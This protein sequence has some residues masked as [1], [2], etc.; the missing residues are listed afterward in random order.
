MPDEV[1]SK[2]EGSFGEDFSDV[3]INAN[4]QSAVDAG[5]LAYTQGNNINFAPSQFKPDTQSGQELLGHELTHVVQQR[6]GQ[7]NPTGE[8]NGMPLNDDKRLENE[9]DNKGKEAAQMKTGPDGYASRALGMRSRLGGSQS[10][11][12][13]I[14]RH[15]KG[16]QELKDGKMELDFTK[17][18][19]VAK[20]DSANEKGWVKFHPNEKAPDSKSIKLVQ[21]VRNIDVTGI[22]TAKG[23]AYDWSGSAEANRNKVNTKGNGKD[24]APNFSVDHFASKSNVRTKKSDAEVSPFYMDHGPGTEGSKQGKTIVPATLYDAPG[25]TSPLKWSFVTAA[26]DTNTGTYYGTALWGFETYHDDKGITKIK[27]EYK[28]FRERQGA[29][30]DAAVNEFNEFYKNPGSSNAPKK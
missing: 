4:S 2:M 1:K 28:S 16:S 6:K 22:S 21:I 20:G 18:D 15:I 10:A 25:W 3:E 29:T 7:V 19:G 26:K 11:M 9:A 27:N 23:G 8:V 14:Q 12:M 24:V 5:A 17:V 30:M 13:P